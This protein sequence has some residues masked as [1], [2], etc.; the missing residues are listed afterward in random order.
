MVGCRRAMFTEKF[1]SFSQCCQITRPALR[2]FAGQ[3]PQFGDVSGKIRA[4]RIDHIV[5]PEG[6]NHFMLI[7]GAF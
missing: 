3:F 4:I 2:I 5:W 7:A 1:P 6:G